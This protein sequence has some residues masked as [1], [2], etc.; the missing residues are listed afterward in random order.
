MS[1]VDRL[2]E[3]LET[4]RQRGAVY[5][6]EGFAKNGAALA[7]LF[8]GGITLKTPDDFSRFLIFALCSVKMARYAE[9]FERNGHKDSAHDLGV[10]AFLLE[11]FD[12]GIKK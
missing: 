11:D 2:N 3:A 10:Y 1:I 4:A 12:E 8:K 6:D 5:G 7:A 9:N